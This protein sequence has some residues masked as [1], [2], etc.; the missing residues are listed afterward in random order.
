MKTGSREAELLEQHAAGVRTFANTDLDDRS[1]DFVNA[2]LIGADFTG[3]FIT[4]DFRG[5]KLCGAVFANCNVKTS[6]FRGADLS[7]ASFRQSA[8][9]GADFSGAILDGTDFEGASN[10]GHVYGPGEKP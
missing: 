1:Y 2:V 7:N 6:D 9:D 5:A 10:Q 8:I 3:S 4:A